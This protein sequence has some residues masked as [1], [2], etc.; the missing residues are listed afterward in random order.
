MSTPSRLPLRPGCLARVGREL[1]VADASRAALVRTD[2]TH[3][4][5]VTSWSDPRPRPRGRAVEQLHGDVGG[6][7]AVAD[8]QVVRFD[9]RGRE[10][11][12]HT[13][14]AR[15]SAAA[16]DGRLAVLPELLQAD[17]D[18]RDDA[19]EELHL[20]D[21]DGDVR[22]VPLPGDGQTCARLEHAWVVLVHLPGRDDAGWPAGTLHVLL[23]PD[24]GEPRLGPALAVPLALDPQLV[25]GR[26]C[27]VPEGWHDRLPP[28][29]AR[30]L[31]V[32]PDLQVRTG[33]RTGDVLRSWAAG[34][35][36]HLLT[37][38]PCSRD[39]QGFW[40]PAR[41]GE[42][43]D[44][45]RLHLVHCLD[46]EDGRVLGR[47]T[48][49]GW[50]AGLARAEEAGGE[51]LWVSGPVST[52]DA[53]TRWRVEL[54]PWADGAVGRQL[55][56]ADVDLDGL[57][58][59]PSP[60]PGVDVAAHVAEQLAAAQA[61]VTGAGDDAT[62][63]VR[64]EGLGAGLVVRFVVVDPRLLHVAAW[65][66]LFDDD[67]DPLV[68]EHLDVELV[69]DLDTGGRYRLAETEPDAE[70]LVWLWA[71]PD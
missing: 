56:L 41:D 48:V 3:V 25:A 6:A 47:V 64:G 70:G 57:V 9:Q 63:E 65:V 4:L 67:G 16:P 43:R 10:A 44:L 5:G 24:V 61:D 19:V 1:W 37:H 31:R 21:P 55:D 71:R 52:H 39:S 50:P 17:G 11:G 18:R 38:Q 59:P 40:P 28:G 53:R 26:T 34:G 33:A 66:P 51:A 32:D 46:L 35:R 8:G 69:E 49:A 12:R 68:S 30:L 58:D 22:S 23:V 29:G 7:W 2:G 14:R 45:V 62:V 27:W 15:R 13:L 20:V 36:A 42:P 54:L 60:P